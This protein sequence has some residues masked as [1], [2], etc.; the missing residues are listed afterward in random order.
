VRRGFDAARSDARRNH[1]MSNVRQ[2]MIGMLNYESARRTL[3]PAAIRD[4][5]GRPLLSWRVAIL[6]YIGEKALYDQFRLNEP[7]DSPHNLPLVKRMPEMYRD[8]N[9]RIAA[10]A[11]EGKTTFQVPVGPET[12]FNKNEGARFSEVI[13][14]P[15]RTIMLVEVVPERAVEW[16]KPADWEVDMQN[17]LDGVKR[18]DRDRIT[19]GFG[20]GHVEAMR[21]SIDPK[22]FRTLLTRAGKD[23]VPQ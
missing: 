15:A 1:R 6:P 20:D 22:A 12:I 4:I 10:L 9:P 14:G 17:P 13:D 11:G 18:T 23:S 21:Q 8:P 2:L 7:W 5:E 3:P 16:T 19:A